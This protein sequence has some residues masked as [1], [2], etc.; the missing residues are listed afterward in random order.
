M[1]ASEKIL[2]INGLARLVD[3]GLLYD[4]GQGRGKRYCIDLQDF[5]S[6]QTDNLRIRRN[7]PYRG[8]ADGL[9]T[10]L[11]SLF[12]GIDYLGIEIELNQDILAEGYRW[13]RICREIARC[14]EKL[15]GASTCTST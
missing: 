12:N 11:R 15:L 3:I 5:L 13:R 2:L 7:H 4:P 14:T 8:T 10:W 6:M 9:T 1:K